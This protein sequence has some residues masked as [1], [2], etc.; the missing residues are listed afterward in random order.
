MVETEALENIISKC[1]LTKVVH[2]LPKSVLGYYF[3]DLEDYIVL[4]NESILSDYKLYR[5]VLAEE[6]G[7]HMTTIG[8][9]TPRKYMCYRDRL[10]IDKQELLA[11]KWATDFLIPTASLLTAIRDKLVT[12]IHELVEYFNVTHEFLSR[13]FEFMGRQNPMWDIGEDRVLCLHNL[14]A[15]HIFKKF[16]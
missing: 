3:S 11:L 6:I 13:K 2:A 9:I 1:R 16:S 5:V 4:I 8:D 7:H 10:T 15:V 14:P 12:S